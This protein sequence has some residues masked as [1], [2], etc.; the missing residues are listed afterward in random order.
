MEKNVTSLDDVVVV[1]YQT[2]KRRDLTGSVSSVTR[3]LITLSWAN[4]ATERH[5]KK[6]NRRCFIWL[7][8]I[9]LK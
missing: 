8:L 2:L 9:F 1:G 7:I 4:D 3:P 6:K 5:R